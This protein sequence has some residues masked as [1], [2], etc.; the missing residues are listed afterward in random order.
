MLWKEGLLSYPELKVNV[1]KG[2]PTFIAR[3]RGQEW[4]EGLH[5]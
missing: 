5:L 3:I 4:K 2:G 1:V